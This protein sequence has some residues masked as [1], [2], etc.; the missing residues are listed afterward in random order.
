MVTFARGDFMRPI[1]A[2]AIQWELV[3]VGYI[4]V[5]TKEEIDEMPTVD[6][7]PVRHGKWIEM[8][9]N[10]DGTHNICCGVCGKFKIKSRGHA[11]SAYTKSKYR[12]CGGC[13]AKMDEE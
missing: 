5:I 3:D 11:N 8:G 13:G 7:V 2:D 1:D 9:R 6:A 4:P 10:E 12:F